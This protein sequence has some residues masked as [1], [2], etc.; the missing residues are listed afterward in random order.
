MA[1]RF[2]PSTNTSIG[3]EIELGLINSETMEL[4]MDVPEMLQRLPA[5]WEDSI[6]PEFMRS[7]LE[8]NT[9]VCQTVDDVRRDLSEKLQWG[10]ETAAEMGNTFLW[11]GT[12][13]TSHWKDQ[14]LTDDER[15][16]WL[17]ETMQ[18]VASRLVVFGLHVH[19]G[20]DSGDKAIQMCD[21]LLR[22][23]PVLLALS[24]N[25]PHWCGR[26]TGLHS[27]R[28]K[29]MESL[30]TAGLP[31]TMRNWS[32]FNW[33]TD[34][35]IATD[36]IHSPREI[37]WDVRPVARFGT[38]EIRVMDTPMTMEQLLGLVA[39][40]QCIVS[41]L[42]SEIDRGMY[43]VDCHPMIAR[44]N[45]W[46]AARYGLDATLA[47]PDTMHAIP[48]RQQARLLLDLCQPV[49]EKLGCSEELSYVERILENGSG[50][51]TQHKIA[52]DTGDLKEV[53][54]KTLDITGKP[55][56]QPASGGRS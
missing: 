22:H 12:H 20:V 15:Y 39:M 42:S 49:S 56:E 10:Y 24:S 44:Q 18:F 29:V 38:V 48:A 3:V 50:A 35:L 9:G 14:K 8:F 13:P 37:W 11:S 36:F 32:E 26:N 17:M 1:M 53:I 55:W 33:L 54:R 46:H 52:K 6:K 4:S 30:P 21:R 2:K 28:S 40:T 41:G 45:K 43:L 7:Y 47:D 34:H 19:I 27:Y 23:L 25:S 31:E 5:G 16:K 51:A